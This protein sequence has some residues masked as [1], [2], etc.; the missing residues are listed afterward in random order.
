MTK[1]DSMR[2]CR[3]IEEGIISLGVK[4]G[5]VIYV[6]SDITR[7]IKRAQTDLNFRGHSAR[8]I[9]LDS[10]VDVLQNIVGRD[11]MLL[12]PMYNWDFCRGEMFSYNETKSKVGALNNFVFENRK[13]FL[14]TKHPLYSF[15]VCGRDQQ[16]LV[17]LD[18][19]EAF[20]ANSPFAYLQKNHA[21]QI[22][23]GVDMSGGLTYCHYIEQLAQVPYRH[24]KFFLGEYKDEFGN[25]EFRSY[26]QYV[27]DISLECE[28]VLS[29]AFLIDNHAVKK[30]KLYGWD[31]AFA[32]LLVI[33]KIMMKDFKTGAK[34][35]YCF[36][37]YDVESYF[38]TALHEYE[39]GQ[40]AGY[41]ILK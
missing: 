40:L 27:R 36:K 28:Y 4:Q 31:I 15:M 10:L 3:K 5:D 7:I 25:I 37:N 18:N 33:E 38:E 17:S 32:D 34:N 35:M 14:R 23:L 9:F 22:S 8:N 26:S 13:D 41:N 21:K 6:A 16:Y 2:Y 11:G 20:G 30:K 24:H 12:F 29:D 19:Q 39:V 1:D